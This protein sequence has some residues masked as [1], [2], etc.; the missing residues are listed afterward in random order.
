[1]MTVPSGQKVPSC[2]TYS[3]AETTTGLLWDATIWVWTVSP[4]AFI[5]PFTMPS[6]LRSIGSDR[7]SS[8]ARHCLPG[9]PASR[10]PSGTYQELEQHGAVDDAAAQQHG[11]SGRE[12]GEGGLVPS[13]E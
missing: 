7:S 11:V 10:P 12:A 4:T 6:T 2:V 3:I 8:A 13:L 9:A 1:M 5:R